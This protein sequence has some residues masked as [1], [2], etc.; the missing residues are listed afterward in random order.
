MMYWS[1]CVVARASAIVLQRRPDRS[2]GALIVGSGC[3]VP[4][5]APQAARGLSALRPELAKADGAWLDGDE[6]T[7]GSGGQHKTN[8]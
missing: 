2:F 7:L 8:G 5:L 1:M 3:P 6:R 4:S